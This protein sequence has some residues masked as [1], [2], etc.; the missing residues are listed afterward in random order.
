MALIGDSKRVVQKRSP[1]RLQAAVTSQL[2]CGTGVRQCSA[3][4]GCAPA[5]GAAQ[6]SGKQGA[7]QAREEA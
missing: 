3:V 2:Q 7:G 1:L 4:G 5:L 6:T